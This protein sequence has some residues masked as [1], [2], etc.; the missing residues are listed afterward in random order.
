MP[1]VLVAAGLTYLFTGDLVHQRRRRPRR[2][3]AG[4]GLPL[5]AG[6]GHAHGHRGGHRRPGPPGRAGQGG[7]GLEKL[8]RLRSVV[9]DKTGT[10]TLARLRIAEIVPAAGLRRERRAAPGGAPS[11]GTRS[12]RSAG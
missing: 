7:R 11:S 12:T 4:G 6:A 5:C 10:L 9:F 2:G 1:I 3:R 8:G